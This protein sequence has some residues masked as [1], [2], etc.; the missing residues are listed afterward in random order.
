MNIKDIK[1][2]AKLMNEYDLSSI[3]WKEEQSAIVLK[4]I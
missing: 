4:K 3:E 1:A 2:L